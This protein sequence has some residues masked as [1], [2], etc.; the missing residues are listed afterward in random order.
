MEFF[1]HNTKIDF[2]AQR[3]WAAILSVIVIVLSFASLLFHG[4][5]WGLDFTGGTQVQLS[6]EQ[7]ADLTDIHDRLAQAGFEDA[8]VISFG[9]SRDVLVSLVPKDK[10]AVVQDAKAQAEMVKQV[11]AALPGA[12]MEQVNY[13]GPQVGSEMASK[14][15]LAVIIALLGTMIYIAIRF[16]WYFAVG[17]TVALLHDPIIILGVFSYCNIEFNLISLAAVLTVIGYSLND[18]IVIFDRVR[19][20]FRKFRKADTIEILNLSINQTL[21]R[22]IMT[23][24]LT[25]IVVLALLFIGGS[26]LYGFSLALMIGIIVGTYSS[27]YVAGSLAVSMGLSR[28]HL[29]PVLKEV[30]ET[31]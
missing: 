12:K 28:H 8:V 15:L 25:L 29:I 17:S 4:L 5:N 18:T 27:I 7:P 13:V 24:V 19:E 10:N 31:P 23:S 1:K 11:L 20:N 21:S 3:K 22:T 9:T 26:L 14:G 2:M 30:D 6:Y 16:G